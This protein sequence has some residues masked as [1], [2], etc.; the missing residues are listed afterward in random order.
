MPI[1]SEQ[2]DIFNRCDAII[3][4]KG[5]SNKTLVSTYEIVPHVTPIHKPS[6]FQPRPNAKASET[7][8]ERA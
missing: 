8:S 4:S 6:S 3:V 7:G 1:G 2:I 5:D